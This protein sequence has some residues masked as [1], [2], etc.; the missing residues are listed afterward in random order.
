LVGAA[1]GA[2]AAL[3]IGTGGLAAAAIVGGLAAGGAGVGEL[4]SSM[5]WAPKEVCGM[6][7]TGAPDIFINNRLAARA[8]ADMSICS[9]HSGTPPIATGSAT[10]IFNNMPAARADDK[11]TCGAVIVEGSPDVSIEGGTV[12]T[13]TIQPENLVPAWVHWSL[14]AAGIGAAVIL[15]GPIVAALGLAGGIGGGMG[16][17]W[18]GG[19]IFGQGS[20]GQKWMMLGGSVV[21]GIAS[22]KGGMVLANK[23]IPTPITQTQGFLKGGVPGLKEA[24]ENRYLLGQC[25]GARG[26][27]SGREFDSSKAGGKILNLSND[28]IKITSKGIDA[29]E[30]H[31]SR[32]G[33]DQANMKMVQRL[34]DIEAGKIEA[35]KTDQNF[36]SHELRES[37]R[38]RNSGWPKG[39]PT[40]V[41]EAYEVWNNAHT[42]TL[43]DYGLKEGPGALYH[44]DAIGGL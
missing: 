8:H 4:L 42:A 6:I 10:V 21:G 27:I 5:S 26:A 38:Y 1:V 17:G 22:A 28:N 23:A 2:G 40:S 20:D 25:K 18:L 43:E 30:Q 15:G 44:P 12:Q 3:V 7:I 24:A 36:Y 19:R 37:V 35:T 32:F 31:V 41:D 9:K 29:V 16:C 33:P 11:I 13:D 14:L 34:R 39:Q